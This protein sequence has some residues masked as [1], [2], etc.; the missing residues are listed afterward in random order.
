MY[1]Q[2][3]AGGNLTTNSDVQALVV[4]D[5][6][7][8]RHLLVLQLDKLGVKA[9]SAAN[10]IEALRRIRSWKYQLIIMDIQMPE[11][12]GLQAAASIRIYEK[13]NQQEPTPI[14]ALTAGSTA[15][16][17]C[18]SVGMNDALQKPIDLDGLKAVIDRWMKVG[19]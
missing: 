9:D 2:T 14:I 16:E 12:D 10:G 8:L 3:P 13:E 11:M 7:T 6:I 19:E 18:I 17:T 1:I 15:K 4:D 5:D